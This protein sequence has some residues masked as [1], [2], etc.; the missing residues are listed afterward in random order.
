MYGMWVRKTAMT[1]FP[2]AVTTDIPAG[3]RVRMYV[4]I[5]IYIDRE[6]EI[7][8]YTYIMCIHIYIYIERER[9]VYIYIYIY[10]CRK[11]SMKHKSAPK[12]K[13]P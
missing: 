3:F 10:T 11:G 1:A 12:E 6:R 8:R 9:D 4:Y 13:C 5:Y 2:Q 7:D